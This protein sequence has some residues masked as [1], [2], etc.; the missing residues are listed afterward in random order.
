[1]YHLSTL[2]SLK[3]FIKFVPTFHNSAYFKNKIHKVKILCNDI[4]VVHILS[5]YQKYQV[6]GITFCEIA[7]IKKL[8]F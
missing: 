2:E 7:K 3:L 4:K 1:M 6:S 8:K 5:E